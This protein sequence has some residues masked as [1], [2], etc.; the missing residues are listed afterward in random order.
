MLKLQFLLSYCLPKRHLAS[1]EALWHITEGG[2]QLW[3]VKGMQC[4]CVAVRLFSESDM[5]LERKICKNTQTHRQNRRICFSCLRG[6]KSKP[7]FL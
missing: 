1:T 2:P 7:N 3:N 5:M 4:E 6:S